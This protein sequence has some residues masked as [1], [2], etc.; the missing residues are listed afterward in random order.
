MTNER[1]AALKAS[2]PEEFRIKLAAG[3]KED[4]VAQV[5]ESQLEH[6]KAHPPEDEPKRAAH[7]TADLIVA[8]TK[9]LESLKLEAIEI[10]KRYPGVDDDAELVAKL[11][12][13]QSADDAPLRESLAKREDD[14]LKLNGQ[15]VDLETEIATARTDL[16]GLRLDHQA[17]LTEKEELKNQLN[18]KAERIAQLD[19]ANAECNQQISE[20]NELATQLKSELAKKKK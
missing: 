20:L 19:A 7:A 10:F 4:M 9:R 11:R 1:I 12:G 18:L 5:I 13:T 15:I 2:H 6:D 8:K 14:I 3:L 17:L 16:Q